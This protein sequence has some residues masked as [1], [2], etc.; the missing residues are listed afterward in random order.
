M[1]N[2]SNPN[3][4]AR[5]KSKTRYILGDSMI[6]KPNGYFLTK[7]SKFDHSQAQR[8]IVWLIM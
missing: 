2:K 5:G 8:L 1:K 7:L 3:Y 4:S 6:K